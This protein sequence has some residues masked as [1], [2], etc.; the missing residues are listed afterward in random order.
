MKYRVVAVG[1]VKEKY[2]KDA[3]AEYAKRLSRYGGVEMTE[4]EDLPAPENL[5]EA[6]KRQV[7]EK[8]GRAIL[9][10]LKP[11]AYI[12]AMAVEGR[13]MGSEEFS[14]F[15]S[16][17]FLKGYGS[18]EFI[19]GGSLGLSEEVLRRA[20]YQIS[21]SKMTFPHQLARVILLEQVYRAEKIRSGES[22]HK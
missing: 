6:Q 5:S 22:Y 9:A 2:L 19:I 17:V 21:I 18:V 3:L 20:D 1:G 8:E 4:V 15:L 16:G 13:Q 10:R 14:E 12:V 11:G 7:V